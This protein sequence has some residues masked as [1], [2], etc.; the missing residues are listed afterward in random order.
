MLR[1]LAHIGAGVLLASSVLVQYAH[2][3]T[4][5]PQ[6]APG[7]VACVS[8]ELVTAKMAPMKVAFDLQ[9]VSLT[10]WNNNFKAVTGQEPPAEVDHILIYGTFDNDEPNETSL[11]LTFSNG[12]MVGAAVVPVKVIQI[13]MAGNKV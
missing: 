1:L 5:L 12:C 4:P 2:P 7:A 10:A 3:A 13:I 11:F 8:P 9:G 6:P